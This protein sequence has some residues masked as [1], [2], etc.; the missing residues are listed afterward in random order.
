LKEP[1]VK[2]IRIKILAGKMLRKT[3]KNWSI[4]EKAENDTLSRKI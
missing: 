3:L 2:T 4:L 1:K